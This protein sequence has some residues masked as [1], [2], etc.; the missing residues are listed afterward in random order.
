M[1]HREFLAEKN[2]RIVAE[3]PVTSADVSRIGPIMGNSEV[4]RYRFGV[5]HVKHFAENHCF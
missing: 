1:G 3:E 5:F 2:P 4:F